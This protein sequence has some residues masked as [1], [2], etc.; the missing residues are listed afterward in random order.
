MPPLIIYS[1]IA[2]FIARCSACECKL[3]T[4]AD[5][6]RFIDENM[7]GVAPGGYLNRFGYFVIGTTVGGHAIVI[8]TDD[9]RVS[10]A[11]YTWFSDNE[12]DYQDIGGDGEWHSLPLTLPNIQRS[13]YSLAADRD[14]FLL[15]LANGDVDRVLDPIA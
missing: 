6:T 11:D 15:C 13:L 5:E 8:G 1:D 9:P 3:V 12:I 2:D 7:P 10:F 4:W 14:Q